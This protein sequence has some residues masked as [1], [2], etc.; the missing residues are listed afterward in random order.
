MV[1]SYHVLSFYLKSSAINLFY[2][3]QEHFPHTSF[4]LLVGQI[5]EPIGL[6]TKFFYLKYSFAYLR[7]FLIAKMPLMKPE[8]K[9]VS[10]VSSVRSLIA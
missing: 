4:F 8:N 1:T 9:D 5:Y 7:M 10:I 3:D 2:P 6:L